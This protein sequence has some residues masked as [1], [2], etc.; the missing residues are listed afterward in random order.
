MGSRLDT[1]STTTSDI[2][3]DENQWIKRPPLPS[4][5]D[6]SKAT[7]PAV[8]KETLSTKEIALAQDYLN[9]WTKN[10]QCLLDKLK[11]TIPSEGMIGEVYYWRDMARILE[12]INTEIKQTYVEVCLQMLASI[13]E[14]SIKE[15][16]ESFSKE[17]SRVFKGVKEAKWNSKYMKVIEKPVL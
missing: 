13:N 7:D 4:L 5:Y 2:S 12:G 17:K 16:I 1:P 10:V 15:D 11:D 14:K 6:P 3:S 9:L 8:L